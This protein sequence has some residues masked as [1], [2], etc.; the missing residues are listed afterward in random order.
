[1]YAICSKRRANEHLVSS[2]SMKS[3]RSEENELESQTMVLKI[4]WQN[5]AECGKEIVQMF[6]ILSQNY[7]RII[8]K[9][10]NHIDTGLMYTQLSNKIN[11]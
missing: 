5:G 4:L 7:D 1:M 2:T 11:Y 8:S 9:S 10:W 3:M 6:R